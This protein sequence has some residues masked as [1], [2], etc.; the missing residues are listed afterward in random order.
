MEDIDP[1]RIEV[2]WFVPNTLTT[3]TCLH[4]ALLVF[5]RLL[6]LEKEYTEKT[7]TILRR[8]GVISIWIVSV[9]VCLIPVIS[10]PSSRL[11]HDAMIATLIGG[12]FILHGFHTLP[13]C[14]IVICYLRGLWTISRTRIRGISLDPSIANLEITKSATLQLQTKKNQ[15][16]RMIAA[17]VTRLIICYVPYIVTWHIGMF[18][19][20]GLIYKP[21]CE[22]RATVRNTAKNLVITI[23]CKLFL[24]VLF[25]FNIVRIYYLANLFLD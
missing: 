8:A 22:H 4:V 18:C 16:S 15:R 17:N 14:L 25:I 21:V 23:V 24:T 9:L 6:E 10:A 19:F 2:L 5:I 11:D 12:A 1:W 20:H 7:H 3:S 13:I